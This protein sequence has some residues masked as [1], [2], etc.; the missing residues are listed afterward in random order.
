MACGPACSIAGMGTI[1]L[2]CLLLALFYAFADAFL[3]LLLIRKGC[4]FQC[5][6]AAVVRQGLS[7]LPA[8]KVIF[9]HQEMCFPESGIEPGEPLKSVRAQRGSVFYGGFHFPAQGA[10]GLI[11]LKIH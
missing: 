2:Y 8:V 9:A 4:D 3:Q 1:L 7:V 5:C 11:V 10:E 6:G